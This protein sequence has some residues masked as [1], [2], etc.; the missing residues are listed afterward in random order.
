MTFHQQDNIEVASTPPQYSR[1]SSDANDPNVNWFSQPGTFWCPWKDGNCTNTLSVPGQ[2]VVEIM[3]L[4][5]IPFEL[6]LSNKKDANN[7]TAYSIILSIDA[8]QV[9]LRTSSGT[10]DSSTESLHTL[11][12]DDG[13]WH[14][15]WISFSKI[16]LKAIYGIGEVRPFFTIL[17]SD[18]KKDDLQQ[19]KEI[20]YIHVKMNNNDR[21]LINLGHL[22][23]KLRFY[24]GQDPVIEEPPLIVLPQEQYTLEHEINHS[25]VLVNNLQKPCRQLYHSIYNFKLNTDDFPDF[26]DVIERSIRNPAGWCHTKLMEKANRFGKPNFLVTYLRITAGRVEGHAPGHSYVIEMWPP[27]HGSPI[28]KHG[29]AYSIIRVLRGRILVKLYPQLILNTSLYKPIETIFEEGQVTWML[30]KLNQI[31]QL[32][33]IDV[34]GKTAITIQCYKYGREDREHYEYFDYIANDGK[35]IGHFDPKSDMDYNEF[36]VLMKQERQNIF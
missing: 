21:M 34:H 9:I 15:Y 30:P 24:I 1:S 16:T 17:N 13:S 18:L 27:G 8:N 3:Q 5:S 10:S 33:N 25:A 14:T 35:S 32:Q 22:R 23:D 19:I 31:H 12:S 28:H 26:V 2:G 36:K 11:Q 4:K 29:N 20:Q 7:P 6:R